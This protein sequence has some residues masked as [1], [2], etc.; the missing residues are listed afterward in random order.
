MIKRIKNELI[1]ICKAC[2][3]NIALQLFLLLLS[4][5]FVVINYSRT[6]LPMLTLWSILL[7]CDI[8]NLSV[9]IGIK[10][11]KSSRKIFIKHEE[12]RDDK[13]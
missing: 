1:D 2:S 4:V 3:E 7:G 9:A 11:G 8:V 12:D 10:K 5:V 6:N 13:D